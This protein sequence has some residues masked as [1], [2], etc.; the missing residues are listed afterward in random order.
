MED[1]HGKQYRKRV[2]GLA[3]A[4]QR[5]FYSGALKAIFNTCFYPVWERT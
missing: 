4:R 3:H 5:S 2:A 1:L